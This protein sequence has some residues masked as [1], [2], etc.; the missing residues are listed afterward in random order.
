MALVGL[1]VSF[2]RARLSFDAVILMTR[3]EY[4]QELLDCSH[5]ASSISA[6]L[7]SCTLIDQIIDSA[8]P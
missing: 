1:V 3:S 6:I 8:F 7:G 5:V 2:T 4:H